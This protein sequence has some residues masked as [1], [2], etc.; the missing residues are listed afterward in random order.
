MKRAYGD[1]ANAEEF[2]TPNASSPPRIKVL[3]LPPFVVKTEEELD[4][5]TI[6]DLRKTVIT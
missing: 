5:M 2:K 3:G 1:N 4:S 6:E